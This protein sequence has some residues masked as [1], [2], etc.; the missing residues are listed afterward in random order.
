MSFIINAVSP[1]H[2][3]VSEA[4][5]SFFAPH[6]WDFTETR[7]VWHHGACERSRTSHAT[8]QTVHLGVRRKQ[9]GCSLGTLDPTGRSI[10]SL[11]IVTRFIDGFVARFQLYNFAPFFSL[12][13]VQPNSWKWKLSTQNAQSQLWAQHQTV[14]CTQTWLNLPLSTMKV[15]I[16]YHTRQIYKN[17]FPLPE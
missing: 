3:H 7:P 1:F 15:F 5:F 2:S 11:I 12:A 13:Q 16:Q 17:T 14:V 8:Q 4:F 6:S 9:R 10:V